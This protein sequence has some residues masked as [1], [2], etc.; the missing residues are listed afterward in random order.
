M[1]IEAFVHGAMCMSFPRRWLSTSMVSD[2][3]QGSCT[4]PCRWKYHV[5]EEKDLVSIFH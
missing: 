2:A 4:H 5:V 3:N 1:E